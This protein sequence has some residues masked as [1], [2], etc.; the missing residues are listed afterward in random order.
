MPDDYRNVKNKEGTLSCNA[1]NEQSGSDSAT[2]FYKI[3][4][5][6]PFAV[7]LH[8]SFLCPALKKTGDDLN[9]F[10]LGNGSIN[11]TFLQAEGKEDNKGG[12]TLSGAVN[13][14]LKIVDWSSIDKTCHAP[15][16]LFQSNAEAVEN[17]EVH[18]LWQVSELDDGLLTDKDGKPFAQ[19]HPDV[20]NQYQQHDLK[21][22]FQIIIKNLP[23]DS[24]GLYDISWVKYEGPQTED[25]SGY[26]YEL[27][28]QYFNDFNESYRDQYHDLKCDVSADDHPVFTEEPT[29]VQSYHPLFISDK[30]CLDIGHLSD[31]HV[32]SRQHL[33]TQSQARLIDSEDSFRSDPIGPMVN[34]SYAN[35]KDLMKQMGDE[36]D[37]L[38]FTGDLIDY[39]RNFNPN[40]S[41][42]EPEELKKCSGIWQAL[43]LTNLTDKQRYPIGI[44][45]LVMY[46]L[47]RWYYNN[48]NKPILLVSGNHEAYT[49][50]YGISPRVKVKRSINS[51]Y[52]FFSRPSV[53]KVIE[54]SNKQAK[55]D[56]KEA[57][58]AQKDGKSPD[59]YDSRANEGIPADHNLTITEAILMY[60]PDYARIVMSASYNWGNEKNFRPENLKWFFHIFTPLTSFY[61]TYGDQCFVALGWGDD[62]RF[63]GHIPKAQGEWKTGGFLPRSVEGVTTLQLKILNQALESSK[64]QNVLCSHFTYINYNTNRPI[65]ETGMV[66][67]TNSYGR[68]DYGTFESNRDIVY[69][70]IKDKIQYALSG[71]SHRSGLYQ[72]TKDASQV[73]YNDDGEMEV[74]SQYEVQGQAPKSEKFQPNSGVRFLV[75]ASGGPIPV[76]NHSNELYNWGLDQPSGNVI[77]FSGSTEQKI[78]ILTSRMPQSKPRLAVAL[79]YADIFLRDDK[80]ENGKPGSTFDTF[81][82]EY[83]KSAFIVRFSDEIKHSALECITKITIHI[84]YGESGK[85][86][87]H[88]LSGDIGPY[89]D[90]DKDKDKDKCKVKYNVNTKD[91][92][93][94]RITTDDFD[95]TLEM[96]L[97]SK[98]YAFLEITLKAEN[99]DLTEYDTSKNWIFPIEILPRKDYVIEEHRKNRMKELREKAHRGHRGLKHI[100]PS[101]LKKLEDEI[102]S[103]E[104]CLFGFIIQRHSLFGEIPDFRFYSDLRK[105]EYQGD[106]IN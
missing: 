14:L 33:F 105:D 12:P 51:T 93:S 13:R 79:D 80:H 71:H 24:P 59:I 55:D 42:D 63:V 15:T 27:Q 74:I 89:Q 21:W 60:G 25:E 28:D 61:L 58:K 56:A 68:H 30:P 44:D 97:Q 37:L 34:T 32:S 8:P 57:E 91:A 47:F 81:E 7:I 49:L 88:S 41:A 35:L 2:K 85:I 101:E 54:K 36:I 64:A 10:I 75:A 53:D 6:D 84:S 46:E 17:I 73:Y 70:L 5:L 69:P 94:F 19:I 67:G 52:N 50:P 82:S 40:N 29:E 22:G 86:R 92:I 26:F 9:L 66:N 11:K 45:N 102:K 87:F 18:Y 103:L 95:E 48:Y 106:E 23:N 96:A 90:K 78:G 100:A 39:N 43:N 4:I 104:K 1:A 65:S 38:I 72:I 62:E 83:K 76:Q 99:S 3:K 20:L 31:V 16:A 98:F 77:K